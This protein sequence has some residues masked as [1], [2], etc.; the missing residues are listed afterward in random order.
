M[1][2]L[3]E[4][5]SNIEGK[6]AEK[7]ESES[8]QLS[9]FSPAIAKELRSMLHASE[10]EEQQHIVEDW[11]GII[12]NCL[13]QLKHPEPLTRKESRESLT[14]IRK[15]I[16]QEKLAEALHSLP[17]LLNIIREWR[18]NFHDDLLFGV[19]LKSEEFVKLTTTEHPWIVLEVVR[20]FQAVIYR[21]GSQLD[22]DSW[23]MIL[24]SLSSWCTTLEETW[25][26]ITSKDYFQPILLSF[27]I[28]LFRLVATTAEYVKRVTSDE[29][30]TTDIVSEWNDV[31]SEEIY[32]SIMFTFLSLPWKTDVNH[33]A[34]HILYERIYSALKD[35][36]AAHVKSTVEELAPILR[37]KFPVIQLTAYSLILRY[38]MFTLN[39]EY[40][41]LINFVLRL[42]P[43]LASNESSHYKE[44]QKDDDEKTERLP[45]S[46]FMSIIEKSSLASLEEMRIG[47]VHEIKPYSAECSNFLGYCLS[48]NLVIHFCAN[49]SSEL[50]SQYATSLYASGQAPQLL[51][52]LF[53]VIP[54][55]VVSCNLMLDF[56]FLEN[57]AL[58][59]SSLQEVAITTYASALRH[60]PA[61]V[62][63]WVNSGDKRT[64][65][66]VEKFT[67]K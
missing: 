18:D 34:F 35:I 59:T 47:E 21:H 17:I 29:K 20:I 40:S 15:L 22:S 61:L 56:S 64:A 11:N 57:A 46:V 55:G 6:F 51:E 28:A 4:K 63:R 66:I 24:C 13:E 39:I 52:N 38:P 45:P 49:V 12:E 16:E 27:T 65:M 14:A 42:V 53:R 19:D 41:I 1:I 23:D 32:H 44:A 25:K 26:S 7:S 10:G 2:Q 9:Y 37:A 36:P 60:L 62:R 50:R 54:H 5:S 43:Q 58:T 67:S 8:R 31:F 3:V 33:P 48:W 30:S